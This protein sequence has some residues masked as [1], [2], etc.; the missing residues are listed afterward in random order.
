MARP[1]RLVDAPTIEPENSTGLRFAIDRLR[2]EGYVVVAPGE[3]VEV[4][5]LTGAVEARYPA[6]GRYVDGVWLT[7][8]ELNPDNRELNP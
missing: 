6:P 4:T 7:A 8:A 1:A 3:L 2:A 5:G